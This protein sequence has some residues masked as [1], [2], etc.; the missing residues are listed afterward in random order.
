MPVEQNRKVGPINPPHEP[1]G[2]LG[3]FLRNNYGGQIP[4]PN[5]GGRPCR[6]SLPA[7]W[8]NSDAVFGTR[9]LHGPESVIWTH[10]DKTNFLRNFDS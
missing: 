10:R 8:G 5:C 3:P 4:M 7:Q 2:R 6:F 1:V 9:A